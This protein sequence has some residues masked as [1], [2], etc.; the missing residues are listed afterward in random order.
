MMFL[1]QVHHIIT[2]CGSGVTV[3]MM[4]IAFTVKKGVFFLSERGSIHSD[5]CVLIIFLEEN[6][7]SLFCKLGPDVNLTV[8]QRVS[9]NMTLL[10][11]SICRH[12]S[13]YMFVI[14]KHFLIG[15]VL[16]IL[17]HKYK[18]VP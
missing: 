6:E 4:M 18:L 13:E 5:M 12:I 14:I 11:H 16:F 7:G 1:N 9:S 10:I 8:V 2:L 15:N 3:H 17:C